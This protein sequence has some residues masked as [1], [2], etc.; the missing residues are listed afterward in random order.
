MQI[1][2]I[3]G[4]KLQ[5]KPFLK[6]AGGKTQLLASIQASLPVDL[7]KLPAFTY[8]EP[9]TGSG[10]LFFWMRKNFPNMKKAIL[11]DLNKDL[12]MA[13]RTIQRDPKELLK[14]LKKIEKKYLRLPT[15]PDRKTMFLDQ[16]ELFN[17]RSSSPILQTALLLFLNKTCFNGLYRVNRNNE[18]NVPFGRYSHPQICDDT[19]IFNAHAA[20]KK[21][22]ILNGDYTSTLKKVSGPAFFYFDPP[23]RPLSTTASFNAYAKESFDDKEQIRLKQFC[24]QLDEKNIL[25]LLS[26]SDPKN[27][28]PKDKFFDKLYKGYTIKRV[29]AKRMI[30]SNA[31]KRG[32]I[33]ELLI[34]NYVVK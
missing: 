26:N 8:V 10:A 20:L 6:W 5:A 28:D 23:Y 34:H 3:T 15:E 27:V 32:S 25:W 11:N 19:A 29:K 31:A 7:K 24:D 13:Y 14:R 22:T 12:V 9:F 2:M 1:E 21:V 16:R 17:T 18:F 33:T 4:D 30:N